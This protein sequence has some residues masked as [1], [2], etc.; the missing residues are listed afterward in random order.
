MTVKQ[1]ITAIIYSKKGDVLSVGK[2]S[3]TKSH[4]LQSKYAKQVGLPDKIYLHAEV[5]AIVRCTDLSKA[6]RIEV[7]RVLADGS[8][9]NAKPCAICE[10]AIRAVGIKVVKW[11]T[12]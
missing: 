10:S 11:S 2:N 8:Y 7:I 4:P 3:Y 9:G 1:N 5:D 6:H 12:S